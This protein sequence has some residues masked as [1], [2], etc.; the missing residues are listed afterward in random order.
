MSCKVDIATCFNSACP[1]HSSCLRYRL[2]E[3]DGWRESGL[4]APKSAHAQKC[5]FFKKGV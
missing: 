2:G 4:F 3:K 5:R 1:S